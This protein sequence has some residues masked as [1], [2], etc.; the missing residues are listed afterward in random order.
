MTRVKVLC[1]AQL[2]DH[3]GCSEFSLE[4]E[5]GAVAAD[6]LQA[7]RLRNPAIEPLLAVCRLAVN[8]E[9]AAGERALKSGDEVVVIPPVSGG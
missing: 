3:F 7:L 5:A 2:K 1:F 6:V 4:L 8:G 9:Y